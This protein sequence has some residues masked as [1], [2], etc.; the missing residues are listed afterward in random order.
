MIE[1]AD[2]IF[3]IEGENRG[4]YPDCHGLLV[5]DDVS[6]IIDPACREDLMHE[7]AA[8]GVDIVL[9]THYHEDHRIYNYVFENARLLAHGLDAHGYGTAEEFMS[10]FAIV[11]SPQ[12]EQLW[13]EFLFETMK[14]RP[15]KIDETITDGQ[16]ID[17]GHTKLQV[18]HT[19]GH[20]SGHCCFFFPEERIAYLGDVDLTSFG[21]WYASSHSDIE[22]F[23]T[24]IERLRALAPTTVITSHGDGLISEEI[25]GEGI[26]EESIDE[27]LKEYALMIGKREEKIMDFVTEPRSL[28]EILGLEIIYRMKQK[29]PDAFFYWD[30]RWM[31]ELHLDRL[32]SSDRLFREN[33]IYSPA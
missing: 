11:K 27:R 12:I 18:I 31:I 17:F 7:I 21:P 2:R 14:Y 5:K 32:V 8:D 1:I 30:D 23:L 22:D 15:Y 28:D 19:P 20:S 33:N 10:G 25:R 29:A 9:N 3:Y 4:K 24:S 26:K 6:A 16:E 13:R